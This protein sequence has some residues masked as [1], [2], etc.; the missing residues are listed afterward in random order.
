[1]KII[2]T[3]VASVALLAALGAAVPASAEE[4]EVRIRRA[5]ARV[6]VIVENR[7][8]IAVEIEAG[9]AG[10]PI[11]TVTRVG[12]EVRIDGTLG[13]RAFRNCQSGPA[14][15]R[16]PGEGASVEVRDHGRVQLSAAP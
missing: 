7:T 16:Q 1:M 10:L 13:R 8:D 2:T 5:A 3:A 11:P 14:G 4:A 12:N 15:A 9:S 6:V